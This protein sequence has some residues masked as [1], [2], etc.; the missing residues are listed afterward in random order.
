MLIRAIGLAI[1]VIVTCLAALGLSSDLL[2]DWLWF[3]SVGYAG[4]F[5]TIFR[6][7]VLI[8]FAVFAASAGL[9]W[10]NGALAYRFARR[11]TGA[12]AF[13]A[14][15]PRGQ[16]LPKLLK[17][18]PPWLPRRFLIAMVSIATGFLIGA[19][20]IGNWGTVL[21]FIHQVPY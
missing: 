1:V 4:V 8:F 7:Q 12:P 17:G 14:G 18:V 20:E 11:R 15:S 6:A 19:V 10:A 3:S 2:V 13:A 5:W 9:V 16:T 21:R